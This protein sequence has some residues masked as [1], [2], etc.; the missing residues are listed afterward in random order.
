LEV[1]WEVS[2]FDATRL[3]VDS[4]ASA[5][6]DRLGGLADPD[7]LRDEGRLGHFQI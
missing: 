1:A 6:A 4:G 2:D 3:A 5:W 7:D